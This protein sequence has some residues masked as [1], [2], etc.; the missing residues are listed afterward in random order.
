MTILAFCALLV[1][2]AVVFAAAFMSQPAKPKAGACPSGASGARPPQSSFTVNVY[3]G[4]GQKGAASDAADALRTYDFSVGA[5]GNDPYRKTLSGAGE[6]R[7]GPSGAE[8]AKKYVAPRVPGV[9]LVEDGRD[10]TGVDV[11]VGPQFSPLSKAA[12]TA[13]SSPTCR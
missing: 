7:F 1:V 12:A 8:N 9:S 6:I 2:G 3:N 11:V 5:V 10:G 13:S 4:G